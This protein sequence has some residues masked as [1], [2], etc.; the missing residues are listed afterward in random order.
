MVQV[1]SHRAYT[2]AVG[3]ERKEEED[4]KVVWVAIV[5]DGVEKGILNYV[6]NSL[7]HWV[8]GD[9]TPI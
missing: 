4:L 5:G 6:L 8:I 9:A 7:R 3:L 2:E 1:G